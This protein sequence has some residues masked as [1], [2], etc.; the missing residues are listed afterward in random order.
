MRLQRLLVAALAVALMCALPT[1]AGAAESRS[2]GLSA[3]TFDFSAAPGS[4]GKGE[5]FV[6]NEGATPMFVKVYTA[7]QEIKA[8]G[9]V[10][11]V[12]PPVDANPL[13]S[14]A[15]WLRVI[16]P[17]D[18]KAQGNIPYIELEAGARVPVSFEVEVPKGATPGDRQAILFFEM[19]EP[20]EAPEAGTARVNAR[21]GARVKTRVEGAVVER[22]EVRPFQVPTFVFGDRDAYSFAL[23][24]TGNVDALVT[25]RLLVLDSSKNERFASEVLTETP[26]Y[27]NAIRAFDGN[28]DLSNATLGRFTVRLEVDYPSAEA[29]SQGLVKSLQEEATVWVIPVWLAVAAIVA[30]GLL[31]MLVTWSSGRKSAERRLREERLAMREERVR[32]RE[33]AVEDEHD[34]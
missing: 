31:A 15:S 2:L 20:S 6:I 8:D 13:A 32:M 29:G 12:T 33:A 16:L 17:N 11:Y 18:A 23:R 7:N 25:A 21:I 34:A 9:T 3:T 26:V 4:V 27:A 22:L 14:P 30:I 1:A 5:L 19:F 28:L 24:N 10:E